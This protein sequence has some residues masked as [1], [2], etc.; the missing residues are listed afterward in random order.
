VQQ[1]TQIKSSKQIEKLVVIM[2]NV[3]LKEKKLKQQYANIAAK[4]MKEM[5]IEHQY[6]INVAKFAHL[7]L[8]SA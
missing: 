1:L 5:L 4:D 3:M 7:S 6:A 2:Q 8:V